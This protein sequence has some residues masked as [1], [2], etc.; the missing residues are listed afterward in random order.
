M[1]NCYNVRQLKSLL[2]DYNDEDYVV[3]SN[4]EEGNSFSPLQQIETGVYVPDTTRSG[5]VYLRELTEELK[6]LGYGEDDLCHSK[7]GENVI[8]LYPKQ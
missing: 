7:K 4:D 8:I 6:K 2:E 1:N 3:L 5:T